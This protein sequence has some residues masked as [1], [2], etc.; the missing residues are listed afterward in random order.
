MATDP[1]K[2]QKKL[3]KKAAKRKAVVSS[4]K[5]R[6][7]AMGIM[8]GAHHMSVAAQ[9]SLHECLMGREMFETG[10][11]TV[12]VSRLMPNG[13]I[14]ASF[15]LLD[16][17]C[18][19]VKNAYFV[20]ETREDYLWRLQNVAANEELIPIAPDYTRKLVEGTEAYAHDLGFSPHPDYQLAKKI[21]ADIDATTCTT[22]FTF[23]KDGKPFYVMGPHDTP[24][25][26]QKILN[27]L[28][29]RCGPE[30]FHYLMPLGDISELFDDEDDDD[31]DNDIIEATYRRLR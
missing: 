29:R 8:S 31:I 16:V 27:T 12:I 24:Q 20:V 18:L 26:V 5:H 9:M 23:G 10:M 28:T 22:A 11:G 25:H 17:F 6:G 15:F 21:F 13:G 3:A 30:G 7:G 19:G 1:R 2:R 4:K 14:A